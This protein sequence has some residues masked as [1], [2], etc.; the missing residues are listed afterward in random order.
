MSPPPAPAVPLAGRRVLVLRAAAQADALAERVAALGGE[1]VVAPVLAIAPGDLPALDTALG[2]AAAG[3]FALLCLTSPNGVDAVAD[4]LARLGLAPQALRAVPRI[5]CVGPGTDARLAARLGLRA[6]LLP[7]RATTEALGAAV[8]PGRGRALL[9]RADLANPVLEELLTARGYDC[10]AVTAYRTRHTG[11][12]PP[13]VLADLAAGRIDLVAMGS[14]ST[15]AGFLAAV[16]DAP[17]HADVVAIGPVT[18]AACRSRGLTVSVEAETHDLDG[19][20]AALVQ[21]TDPPDPA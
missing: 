11:A 12:L 21:A 9:A 3:R 8:P 7:E 20:V 13:A 19:L 5:A 14:P 2:E 17:W 1:P 4:G 6:D 15:V 18:A 10:V 16:G